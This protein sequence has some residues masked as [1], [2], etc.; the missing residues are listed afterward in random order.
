MSE[1]QRYV[2]QEDQI[3]A[4]VEGHGYAFATDMNSVAGQKVGYMYRE[5][6]EDDED[7]GWCFMSG[8]E[9]QDYMDD[10][11]NLGLFDVNTIAN[12]DPDII[13]FLDSPFE[14]AYARNE[15]TG[16]FE[17]VEYEGDDEDEEVEEEDE[18]K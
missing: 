17:E 15:E 12:F 18:K 16:V 9:T 11:N 1:E 2:L 6:P 7:S 13:P 8:S 3:E 10:P 5:E 4:L 14:T